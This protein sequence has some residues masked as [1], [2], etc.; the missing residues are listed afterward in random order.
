[1]IN[2]LD[3]HGI[4]HGEV[5]RLVENFVLLNNPPLRIIT[6]N[7]DRMREIVRSLH[8]PEFSAFNRRG[9]SVYSVTCLTEYD[10]KF[11]LQW[12]LKGKN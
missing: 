10:E 8:K 12:H 7:S 4:R 2:K 3:L 11:S 9:G 1:M 5:D 6:G